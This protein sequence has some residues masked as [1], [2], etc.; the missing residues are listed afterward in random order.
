MGTA[1]LP[2]NLLEN[3]RASVPEATNRRQRAIQTLIFIDFGCL[4]VTIFVDFGIDP[5][6]FRICLPYVGTGFAQLVRLLIGAAL[7]VWRSVLNH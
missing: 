1:H 7:V 2:P 4:L 6:F 3:A 5:D